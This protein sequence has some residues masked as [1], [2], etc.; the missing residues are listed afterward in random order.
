[1]MKS[2]SPSIRQLPLQIVGS[3]K[4]GRYQKISDEQTYN[5]II[6]DNFLVPYA[7]FKKIYNLSGSGVGR[8]NY[9]STRL[10]KDIAVV[11]NQV[12]AID[13]NL[14]QV[15]IGMLESTTGD[16]SIA[17]NSNNQ[18]AICDKINIYIY[19]YSLNT[20]NKITTDFTPSYVESQNGRFLAGILNQ[21][22]WRLS[23]MHK[24]GAALVCAGPP[25]AD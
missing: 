23:F 9:S 5:M 11:G 16:V 10:G 6:S 3:S 19:D 8:G 4:F 2:K 15:Q 18:I 20:L 12:F 17:E 22:A 14:L 25:S 13:K 7:G 24:G 1:M 21:P